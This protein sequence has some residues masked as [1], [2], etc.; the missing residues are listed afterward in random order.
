MP[1]VWPEISRR[2]NNSSSEACAEA[3]NATLPG[4]PAAVTA[5]FTA[6]RASDQE[7]AS[8]DPFFRRRGCSRRRSPSIQWESNRP[9]SHIQY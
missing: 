6:I 7:T 9:M 3:R 2:T 4:P 1:A 8:Q 5:S